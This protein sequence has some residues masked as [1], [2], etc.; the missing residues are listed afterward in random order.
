MT[1][2]SGVDR[3]RTRCRHCRSASIIGGDGIDTLESW[4]PLRGGVGTS[5]SGSPCRKPLRNGGNRR[6]EGGGRWRPF[7]WWAAGI[8]GHVFHDRLL[9]HEPVVP[10]WNSGNAPVKSLQPSGSVCCWTVAS[11]IIGRPAKR[12]TEITREVITSPLVKS[13][14]DSR[15]YGLAGCV[16]TWFHTSWQHVLRHFQ[17]AVLDW[18]QPTVRCGATR[19]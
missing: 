19:F 16:F 17:P 14:P 6:F 1:I 11:A 8:F 15:W 2:R 18:Q 3:M 4:R 12:T 7:A 9:V 13:W 10:A 5:R